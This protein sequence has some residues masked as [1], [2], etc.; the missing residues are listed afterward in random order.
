ML[1]PHIINS[2]KDTFTS[3]DI[4]RDP[5]LHAVMDHSV[6]PVVKKIHGAF[7]LDE[8]DQKRHLE[9]ALKNAKERGRSMFHTSWEREQYNAVLQILLEPGTNGDSFRFEAFRLLSLSETLDLDKLNDLYNHTL[10]FRTL[11]QPTPPP[12]VDAAPYLSQFFDALMA[13][14]YTDPFFKQQLSDT[15]KLR[16]AQSMQRSLAEILTTLRQVHEVLAYNYTVEQFEQDIHRYTTH[17]ARIYQSLKLVGVTLKDRSRSN[18]DPD[19][20]GIFVPL[21]VTLQGGRLSKSKSDNSII[22]ILE[23]H[24]TIVL[25]GGPGSG[26]ST[27]IRHLTWSH[28]TAYQSHEARSNLTI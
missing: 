13:E 14:F 24:P 12:E 18:S 10:R 19:L 15:L 1:D 17:I 2:L 26:K 3:L 22:T 16:Y 7:N 25:L 6:E 21:H 20:N 11:S 27:I 5:F 23:E 28:T 8:K 9:L 4:L